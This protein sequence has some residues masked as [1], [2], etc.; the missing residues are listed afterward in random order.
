MIRRKLV[1]VVMVSVVGFF[2]SACVD[3]GKGD[4][5][6]ALSTDDF[7]F[8][9]MLVN[10]ADNILI[11]NYAEVQRL[12]QDW[13]RQ[14]GPLQGYCES[15]GSEAE[16]A[17]FDAVGVAWDQLMTAV[18]ITELHLVGPAA[19]NGN[20][21]A[22]RL[23]AGLVGGLSTCGIDQS[24]V[25]AASGSD[26]DI[27]V[28]TVTQRGL[29]ALEYLLFNEDLTHTCPSQIAETAAWDA[30][31]ESERK[32]LRCNYAQTVVADIAETAEA[33][34]T[35]WRSTG[36]DYRSAFLN[37]AN[38][39]TSFTAL[40]D[41]LFFLDLDVK[42]RKVGIPTGIDEGCSS[43]ACPESVEYP[44]REASLASI[45][46][47][48][49]SFEE[50]LNGAGG[51]GFDDVIALAQVP[52]LNERFA[53]GLAAVNALIDRDQPSLRQQAQA[54]VGGVEEAECTNAF[55]NPEVIGALPACNLFGRLKAITDDLKV[56]FVAAIQVD[57]PDRAQTD[58]D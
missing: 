25:Q 20:A 24:V 41:A 29:G 38:V 32:R 31:P 35:A 43:F 3:G 2:L 8:S 39:S 19:D 1:T 10:Y 13:K 27:S 40:S 33:I 36:G 51:P 56:G 50:L 17:A 12:A 52:A 9:A 53:Q 48:L 6:Q 4:N 55:A 58:N 54:I 28:K 26:F 16:D 21:L 49:E 57:L 45:A 23:D 44:Y 15:I 22:A 5:D 34:H 46:A 7:D 30:R 14:D 47:N 11:P 42:D 18:Q 37:P